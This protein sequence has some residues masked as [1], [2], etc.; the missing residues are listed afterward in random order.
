MPSLLTKPRK[1]S[2]SEAAGFF[3]TGRFDLV[4]K[5]YRQLLLI[6]PEDIQAKANLY[7]MLHLQ[8]LYSDGA[9]PRATS[10]KH[11]EMEER[12]EKDV[13]PRQ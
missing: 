7:D 9:R 4:I 1:L 3:V 8:A 13:A 10:R 11:R 12:F 6:E 2:R 5:R